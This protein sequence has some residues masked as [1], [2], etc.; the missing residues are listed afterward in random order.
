MDG[1]RS[2][3]IMLALRDLHQ[4]NVH[5]QQALARRLGVGVT[6]VAALDHLIRAQTPLGPVELADRLRIRSASATVLVDRLEQAGHVVRTPH[7]QDRRRRVLTVS[8]HARAEALAALRP[9]LGP[10]QELAGSLTEE[11]ADV[12]LGFLRRATGINAAFASDV[13]AQHVDGTAHDKT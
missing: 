6:D 1:D 9:L 10:L 2:W 13:E 12:V 7:P 4:A 5:A 3:E 8:E 11:N